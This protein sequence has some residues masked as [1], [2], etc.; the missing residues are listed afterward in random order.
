MRRTSIAR[1]GAVVIAAV[2]LPLGAATS[3]VAQD[4]VAV[5]VDTT[6]DTV[7]F[8]GAQTVADL[9]GPDGRTTLR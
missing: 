3:A 1:F 6:A 7:D 5:T 9:P 8:G 2:L 4:G